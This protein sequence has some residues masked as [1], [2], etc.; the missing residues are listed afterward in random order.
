MFVYIY[1]AQ[2]LVDQVID[3]ATIGEGDALEEIIKIFWKN[4]PLVS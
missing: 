3:H 1:L 2:S 4:S